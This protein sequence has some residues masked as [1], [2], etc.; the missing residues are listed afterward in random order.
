[1]M[2]CLLLLVLI[3]GSL[4]PLPATA[5]SA[6]AIEPGVVRKQIMVNLQNTSHEEVAT[7][8][9]RN[10]T[11]RSLRLRWD[12]VTVQAPAAWETQ[13]CDNNAS[14][15]PHIDT[16]YDPLRGI[17]VPVVLAPGASFELYLHVLPYGRP[18]EATYEIPFRLLGEGSGEVVQ[19]AVFHFRIDDRNYAPNL[20]NPGRNSTVI[21]LYPNP[22]EENFYLSGAPTLSRI[23]IY[24]ALGR[25][26]KMFERPET[27]AGMNV[28]DLPDGVYLVS[29]VD[30]R[31][32][33]VRTLRMLRRGFRP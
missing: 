25:R 14:Y 30:E 24:N 33:V 26:V 17:D 13:I 29:L 4:L 22:V 9:V 16:N 12:K 21:K 20:L 5:Q 28:S 19:R 15:P 8:V 18:G 10:T 32:R 6:L 3:G 27:G 7:I 11:K 31:G 1:M 23:D 2:R